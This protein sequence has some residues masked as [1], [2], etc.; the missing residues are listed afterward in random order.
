MQDIREMSNLF[1]ISPINN[2]SYIAVKTEDDNVQEASTSAKQTLLPDWW[3]ITG[4]RVTSREQTHHAAAPCGHCRHFSLVMW[5]EAFGPDSLLVQDTYHC[6][7]MELTHREK[8]CQE[9]LEHHCSQ[10]ETLQWKLQDLCKNFSIYSLTWMRTTVWDACPE[11]QGSDWLISMRPRRCWLPSFRWASC[12]LEIKIHVLLFFFNHISW[13][14]VR[15]NLFLREAPFIGTA[16]QCTVTAWNEG[17]W[18]AE[19][20]CRKYYIC[21][22]SYIYSLNAQ[23]YESNPGLLVSNRSFC[24]SLN[25][26]V[27]HVWSTCT[28]QRSSA[29]PGSTAL[30]WALQGWVPLQWAAAAVSSSSSTP[31]CCVRHRAEILLPSARALTCVRA[32]MADWALLAM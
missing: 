31:G 6:T 29:L 18:K 32:T 30:C 5:I 11:N 16:G 24:F 22:L 10:R 14:S 12:L 23:T 9:A 27:V 25:V 21:I 7:C 26:K 1:C 20:L 17:S 8:R 15:G 28:E 2:T 13:I 4:T 3:C 19:T